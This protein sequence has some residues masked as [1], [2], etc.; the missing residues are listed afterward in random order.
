MH[1]YCFY[2]QL[3]LLCTTIAFMHN[4]CFYAHLDGCAF[5]WMCIWMDVH[6]VV[7]AQLVVGCITNA[8]SCIWLDVH[9][10]VDAHLVVHAISGWK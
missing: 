9:L 2:A 7:D 4:Y 3:L 1:N 5:G 10:D 6:L 8:F